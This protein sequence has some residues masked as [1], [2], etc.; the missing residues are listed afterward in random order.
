MARGGVLVTGA[1]GFVGFALCRRLADEGERVVAFVRDRDRAEPLERLGVECRRVDIRRPDEVIARFPA[2]VET[3][4][5]MAA[6]FRTEHARREEFHAVN[7]EGTRHLLDAAK[8]RGAGRFVHCSTV[9]VHGAIADPPADENAPFR[10]G[11]HYQRTKAEGERVVRERA[12]GGLPAVIVR[13]VGVYGPGD[14]R[15]LKLFRGIGRGRFVM[16]GSGRNR[17]HMTYIDDLIRGILLCG[18]DNRALGGTFIVAGGD[19]P[20]VRELVDRIAAVLGRPKPRLRVPYGPV[21][22]AS[23]FCDRL[24]RALH[25]SPPPL[26]EE[27]PVLPGGT[28][29]PH[30]QGE[31]DARV[32]P[33][34]RPR[35]GTP[36]HLGLVP[37]KG[38]ALSPPETAMSALRR[39]CRYI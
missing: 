32:P 12:G 28:G 6:A 29:I 8:T 7:V 22:V 39:G 33:G 1:T 14:T 20:T 16:I 23:F 11:D 30:R 38:D 36:P 2:G 10:P 37:G 35:R 34:D 5:H 26:S 13:P 21:L 31:E 15:F 17:Y 9:G 18:R 25:L 27:A 3:V 4:Y 19:C 24:C